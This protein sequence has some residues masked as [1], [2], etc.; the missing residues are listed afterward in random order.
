MGLGVAMAWLVERTDLGWRRT[1]HAAMLVRVLIPG[2]LTALGWLFLLHP[3]IGAVNRWLQGLFGLPSA[4]FDVTTLLGMGIVEGTALSAVVFVMAAG[5]LRSVDASLEEAARANG[6]SAWT[7]FRR[8]TLPLVRPALAGAALFVAVIAISALDVPLVLGLGTGNTVFSSYLYLQTRPA[9]GVPSYGVPAAV[10][11]V[12]VLL[13]L[14]VTWR[15]TRLL[16]RSGR[17]QVLTGKGYRPQRV[18]LGRWRGVAWLVVGA[19]F[20]WSTVLPVLMVFWMST[21]AYVQP[22]SVAALRS[23]GWDSYRELDWDLVGRGL[24]TTGRLM[25]LAPTVAIVAS[26]G[27]SWLVVRSALRT[28]RLYD[29][30]ALL[31]HAVPQSIFAFTASLVALYWTR[32]WYD[33]YG[34]LALLVSVMALAHIAFG[35]RMLNAGLA[36]IHVDLEEAAAIAGASPWTAMRRIVLP[37][38][39]PVLT[40]T[41]LWLALLSA[42]DLTIPALVG[43]AD[44]LTVSMVVWA[45]I[46]TN[47]VPQACAATVLMLLLLVPLVALFLRIG[48]TEDVRAG[49]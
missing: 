14:A 7:T 30:V 36:G 11:S 41:W 12:M 5:S 19:Y 32:G 3:R 9:H 40:S 18:R 6:A 35:T 17:F 21:Q 20:L 39:R 16:D 8:V 47:D 29:A 31:P 34:S 25:V 10:S 22:P 46:S 49:M 2:F 48:R 43:S 26:L 37:L 44:T 33:A 24:A 27:F 1:V 13:A 45:L 15:Y 23:A 28:R 38:L 42:R 4:P